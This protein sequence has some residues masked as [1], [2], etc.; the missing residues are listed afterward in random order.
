MAQVQQVQ[1]QAPSA[2][3]GVPAAGSLAA[4]VPGSNPFVTTSLYVGDLEFNND[5]DL[6]FSR[7][8]SLSGL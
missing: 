7:L 1:P 5:I 6:S 4:A 8:Q 3:N 2:T